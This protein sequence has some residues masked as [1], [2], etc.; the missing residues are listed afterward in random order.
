MGSKNGDKPQS[1][2]IEIKRKRDE[3]M[4]LVTFRIC[5]VKTQGK[6]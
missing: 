1:V 2:D 4:R 6:D 5:Q 3:R